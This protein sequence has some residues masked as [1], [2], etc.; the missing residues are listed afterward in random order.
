VLGLVVARISG[1]CGIDRDGPA[2]FD[3]SGADDFGAYYPMQT[4]AGDAACLAPGT[5]GYTAPTFYSGDASIR[6]TRRDR[7]PVCGRKSVT[8]AGRAHCCHSDQ[9]P[10]VVAALQG[11]LGGGP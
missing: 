6:C 9:L 10:N 4:M 11:R 8:S 1:R 2:Q 7:V 5:E 3:A